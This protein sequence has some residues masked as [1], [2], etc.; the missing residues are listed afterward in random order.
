MNPGWLRFRDGAAVATSRSS[1]SPEPER[2]A[3]GGDFSPNTGTRP[4]PGRPAVSSGLLGSRRRNGWLSSA[5]GVAIAVVAHVTC[6]APFSTVPSRT[7]D[8]EV[9][10]RDRLG[11]GTQDHE[12]AGRSAQRR[13]GVGHTRRADPRLPTPPWRGRPRRT[14]ARKARRARRR[15]RS[16]SP[17]P[18]WTSRSRS[19]QIRAWPCTCFGP[20]AGIRVRRSCSYGEGHARPT[21][22]RGQAWPRSATVRRCARSGEGRSGD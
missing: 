17:I 3:A 14:T 9:P 7:V 20:G 2:A 1:A 16:A 11:R 8:G 6:S 4:S 21:R 5:S 10:G 15:S 13:V 18:G 22:R 19:A 12:Q